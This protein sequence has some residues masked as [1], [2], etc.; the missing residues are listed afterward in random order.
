MSAN[1][2]ALEYDSKFAILNL[3]SISAFL[4]LIPVAVLLGK[5]LMHRCRY[6][7]G[8][9][10]GSWIYKGLVWNGIL[11]FVDASYFYFCLTS[12]IEIRL[13]ILPTP[14]VN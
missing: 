14:V 12:L 6:E 9:R 8:R 7:R 1:A 3:G 11:T 2:S 13:T 10:C 4:V 5:L